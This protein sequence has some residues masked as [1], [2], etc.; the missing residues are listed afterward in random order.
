MIEQRQTGGRLR[1]VAFAISAAAMVS[2]AG[3]DSGSD[4][5][6]TKPTTSASSPTAQD[7]V[8]AAYQRYWDVYVQLANSGDVDPAAFTGIAE[9]GFVEG[10]LKLLSDQSEAG[11]VRVGEPEFSDFS[12]KI[13]A[14]TATSLV[15]FDESGW[16]MKKDGKPLAL[17]SGMKPT[18]FE[19]KLEKRDGGWIVTDLAAKEG[20]PCP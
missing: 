13:E 10:D 9:G 7:D 5:G 20:T 6:P 17:P 15:C 19:A 12:T 8:E 18:P 1:L 2:I 3:C 16:K 14:D 4:D 11:V